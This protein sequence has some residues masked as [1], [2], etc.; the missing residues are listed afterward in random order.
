MTSNEIR[1]ADWYIFRVNRFVLLVVAGMSLE[2]Y[3]WKTTNS[4]ACLSNSNQ[5]IIQTI[6][7][8]KSLTMTLVTYLNIFWRKLT[9]SHGKITPSHPADQLWSQQKPFLRGAQRIQHE[10]RP[11]SPGT[12]L[13]ASERSPPNNPHGPK[14]LLLTSGYQRLQF[15]FRCSLSIPWVL[16]VTQEEPTQ[17]QVVMLWLIS[18]II[19][20]SRNR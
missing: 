7:T 17:W 2:K 8:T 20:C 4:A 12:R 18:V 13:M 11:N 16:S 19:L 14:D 1:I 3:V 10:T 9:N 15:T 6:Q 5:N